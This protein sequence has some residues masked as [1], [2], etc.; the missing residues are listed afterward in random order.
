MTYANS[1]RILQLQ[2]EKIQL[3]NTLEAENESLVNRLTRQLVALRQQ[4]MQQQQQQAHPQNYS[5]VGG[6]NGYDADSA[7]SSPVQ[8]Y[9]PLFDPHNP[10]ADVTINALRSENEMLRSRL[11]DIER[12]FVRMVRLNDVYREELIEHRRRVSRTNPEL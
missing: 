9:A 6:L 3:A 12:E 11:I 5:H 7:S 4:Q 2:E 10:S 1:G 8:N